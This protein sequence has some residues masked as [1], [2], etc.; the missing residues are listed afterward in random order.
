MMSNWEWTSPDQMWFTGAIYL[1]KHDE[2]ANL[3]HYFWGDKTICG[4]K[5][6]IFKPS[7]H[8]IITCPECS[9]EVF[10]TTG[11]LDLFSRSG[12]EPA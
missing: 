2:A 10:Y 9:K 4:L 5:P 1:S 3:T 8:A 12:K 11:T 6:E 7:D